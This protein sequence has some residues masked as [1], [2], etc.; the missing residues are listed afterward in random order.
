MFV[1]ARRGPGWIASRTCFLG[2]VGRRSGF[3]EETDDGLHLTGREDF[4]TNEPALTAKGVA[5]HTAGLQLAVEALASPGGGAEGIVE[6]GQFRG[7]VG[8]EAKGV[9]HIC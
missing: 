4:L 3:T 5:Q 6:R 1:L 9:F 7:A 8:A 2:N